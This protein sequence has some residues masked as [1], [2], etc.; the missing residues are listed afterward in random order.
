MS[1]SVACGVFTQSLIHLTCS[2]YRVKQC[3]LTLRSSQIQSLSWRG[4]A[5]Q[6]VDKIHFC[7]VCLGSHSFSYC[8]NLWPQ[9]R[10]RTKN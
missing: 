10:V 8:Q 2:H 3:S 9:V 6:P 4:E 5:N 1:W 7:Y